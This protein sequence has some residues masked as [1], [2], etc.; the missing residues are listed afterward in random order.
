MV[1]ETGMVASYSRNYDRGTIKFK[2]SP[3]S[4]VKLPPNKNEKKG[5]A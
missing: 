2:A 3:D 1:K 4:L 5:Q